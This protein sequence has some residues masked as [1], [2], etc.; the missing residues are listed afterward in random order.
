MKF[1]FTDEQQEFRRVVRRFLE[2]KSPTKEVRRLMETEAGCERAGWAALSRELGLTAVHIPEA[3]GGQGFGFSE[4]WH[5]ARGDGPRA[6]V[7]AVSSTD[8][9]GR[10]RDPERRQ[11][12]AAR[13]AAAR[14]RRG[15]DHR[16]LGRRR[17]RRPLGRGR[18]D[19]HRREVRRLRYKLDGHKSFVL[20]G[21]TADLIVVLRA[22]P[23]ASGESGLSLFTVRGDAAGLQA[24]AARRHGPDAQARAARRS[25]TSRP[26]L[27][28][29]EGAAA[30]PFARTML[31]APPS[32]SPTRWSAAPSDCAKTRSTSRMMRMQFGRP[33]AS[34]QSLKHKAADML[35]EVELAKSAA[36]YAAGGRSTTATRTSPAT[37]LAGQGRRLRHLHAD[38]DPRRP[39]PRRH[40]LHLGQRHP[41][42]VQAREELRGV[43]RRRAIITASR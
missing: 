21:H 35:L 6:V 32:A 7:R 30:A 16:D 26:S 13:G 1:S 4:H 36:Y 27:L 31:E 5:R 17:G 3:Y 14:H 11:R 24:P 19:A 39:D 18:H 41:S 37:G 8:R 40:R 10:E 33:I 38:G 2:D 9:A 29:D 12:D 22:G 15:Q 28:G 23:A 20:D 34:F 42:L 25:P 43:L